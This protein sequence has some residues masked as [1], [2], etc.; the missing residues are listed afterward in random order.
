[1]GRVLLQTSRIR[2]NVL[3]SETNRTVTSLVD[4]PNT[5]AGSSECLQSRRGSPSRVHTS[6]ELAARV[7]Y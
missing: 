4:I 5:I 3:L 6:G 2:K 7:D 1:M